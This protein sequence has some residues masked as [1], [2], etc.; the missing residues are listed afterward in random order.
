MFFICQKQK[1]IW[2]HNPLMYY[3][4]QKYSFAVL[5]CLRVQVSPLFGGD[6]PQKCEIFVLK[7]FLVKNKSFYL[8]KLNLYPK[9]TYI[10]V[11]EIGDVF[12]ILRNVTI[13]DLNRQRSPADLKHNFPHRKSV[14]VISYLTWGTIQIT[15]DSGGVNRVSHKLSLPYLFK[16]WFL[17][18]WK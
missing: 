14:Y 2:V 1:K 18:V 3:Q 10:Q 9:F 16:V 8:I 15:R 12:L 11:F 17:W 7:I 6:E 4:V 13:I 5:A